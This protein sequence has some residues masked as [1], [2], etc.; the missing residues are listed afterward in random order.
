MWEKVGATGA[1][2]HEEAN[3]EGPAPVFVFL[4]GVRRRGPRRGVR[5]RAYTV[6]LHAKVAGREE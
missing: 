5:L 6:F 4:A 3:V 1:N 2:V